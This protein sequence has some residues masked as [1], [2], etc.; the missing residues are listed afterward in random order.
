[1]YNF[2]TLKW[3]EIE[4][5]FE[6]NEAVRKIAEKMGTK[7]ARRPIARISRIIMSSPSFRT[8]RN[9]TVIPHTPRLGYLFSRNTAVASEMLV[10][11]DYLG[12]RGASGLGRIE[13]TDEEE[14][15]EEEVE[16]ELDDEISVL[17]KY[18]LFLCLSIS[19]S[20]HIPRLLASRA[21]TREL[22]YNGHSF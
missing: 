17:E 7:A 13:K 14:E 12:T 15:K 11:Q 4:R 10:D 16:K 20:S 5:D 19:L 9:V 18:S 6:L 8:S 1:M 22:I 2:N 3:E 21:P